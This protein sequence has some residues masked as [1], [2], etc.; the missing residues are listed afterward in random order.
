MSPLYCPYKDLRDQGQGRRSPLVR[1][2]SRRGRVSARDEDPRPAVG[3][4]EHSVAV[5]PGGEPRDDQVS[6]VMVGRGGELRLLL[7]ATARSPALVTVEGEAGVGKTRLT[8]EFLARPELAGRQILVGGCHESSTPFP[9]GPLLEV[10]RAARFPP[11]LPA[12]GA[13]VR[14]LMPELARHLPEAL[15]DLADRGAERHRLYRGLLALLSS[16]GPSVLVVEDLHWADSDTVDF[17]R[18]LV[19]H[20][21]PELA[22]VCTYRP[23]DIP[24]GSPLP[25]LDTRLPAETRYARIALPALDPEQVRELARAVLS[26]TEIP[27]VLAGYLLDRT[28]GVPRAVEEVLLLLRRHGVP[29][30]PGVLLPQQLDELGVPRKLRGAVA[31]RLTRLSPSARS[32]VEAAAVLGLPADEESLALVCGL[33]GSACAD[34][35]TEALAAAVLVEVG[36]GRYGFRHTAARQSVE[37]GMA[38]PLRRRV[39][40]RTARM[41]EKRSGQEPA[42]LA[43]HYRSAG[44]TGHLAHYAEAA[45]EQATSLGDHAAVYGL[46]K[47][48]VSAGQVS[49]VVRG[50]LAVRLARHAVRCRAHN[51]AL[52]LLRPLLDEVDIPAR[53]RGRLRFWVGRLLFDTGEPQAARH[54]ATAALADLDGPFAAQA[55]VWLATVPSGFESLSRR[56]GWIDCAVAVASRSRDRAVLLEIAASRA[57]FLAGVGDAQCWKAIADLPRP[58]T[59]PHEIEQAVRG[60]GNIAD[61][62][63]HNGHYRRARELNGEAIRLA[64]E[65][66]SSLAPFSGLTALQVDWL[67]GDWQGL[68]QRLRAQRGSLEDWPTGLHL[69]EALTGLLLLARGRA[70][71][72]LSLLEPLGRNFEGDS[73][74]M[75]WVT[76]GIARARLAERK[77]RAAVA[78]VAQGL[79]TV[80]TE[81]MWLS[82]GDLLAISVEA[83]VEEGLRSEADRLTSCLAGAVEGRDAPAAAA[84]LSVCRGLLAVAD[85][86]PEPAA[87]LFL[88]A[89]LAWQALPRPYEAA[90]ARVRAGGCLLPIDA[91]R[92]HGLVL[93]ALETFRELG[94]EWEAQLARHVLRRHGLIPPHRRGRRPYGTELSPRE[95]EVLRLA[96]EGN[97]NREIAQA[98]HLSVKTVEGHLSSA[99]RKLGVSP[100]RCPGRA[101][102]PGDP[103]CGA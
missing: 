36:S 13:A 46:L 84:A 39:H 73:R 12:V 54:E 26:V 29:A 102:P 32:V 42:R 61:A 15:P 22:V 69:S 34:A 52:A 37:E 57:A 25:S 33:D 23:E 8:R 59:A 20:P 65:D 98:L 5:L 74:V 30:V 51:E 24:A 81:G 91:A 100:E 40:L 56:L 79:R 96:A 90:R 49:P 50:T 86:R 27:Q 71:E 21:P 63:L 18:F 9:L 80:E 88:D 17:L 55:M 89:D 48:V 82:A 103:G 10:L 92:G 87:E 16:L 83:L 14:P 101:G 78:E 62:L 35:L 85:G 97:R 95:A 75:A 43:R 7:A 11:T 38:A 76:A 31:E 53:L 99:R 45:S 28:A 68:E 3:G 64:R 72:G 2:L 67:T 93:D 41:L 4:C 1:T 77:P 60:Y 58:G 44:L 47:G 19:V 70:R 6:P 66:F 94:G